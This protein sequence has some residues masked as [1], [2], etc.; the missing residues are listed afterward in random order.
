MPTLPAGEREGA[1]RSLAVA[2]SLSL[3]H[4]P[5]GAYQAAAVAGG[6]E[7]SVG[8]A[9]VH[10]GR[11]GARAVSRHAARAVGSS[12]RDALGRR[13]GGRAGRAGGGRCPIQDG[14]A[15]ISR[16]ALNDSE[17]AGVPH[18]QGGCRAAPRRGGS[19]LTPSASRPSSAEGSPFYPRFSPPREPRG[20]GMEVGSDSHRVVPACPRFSSA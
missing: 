10:E 3:R 17:G 2:P 19:A 12:R 16:S 20:C 9:R 1:S 8:S 15:G 6:T 14:G 11:G 13:A 5:R 18:S 7:R 4:R